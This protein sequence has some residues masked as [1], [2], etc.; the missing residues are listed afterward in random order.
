[1]RWKCAGQ[2]SELLSGFAAPVCR[3]A[4]N[5][6]VM[7]SIRRSFSWRSSCEQE[8]ISPNCQSI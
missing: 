7:D 1:M 5:F 8:K 6:R 3:Y 2:G 4:S